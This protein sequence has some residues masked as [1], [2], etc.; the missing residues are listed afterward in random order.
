[1]EPT[2]ASATAAAA[3]RKEKD[4]RTD[5]A[6]VSAVNSG[7]ASSPE[8]EEPVPGASN[9]TPTRVLV[10]LVAYVLGAS[11]GGISVIMLLRRLGGGG[12]P[13]ETIELINQTLHTWSAQIAQGKPSHVLA[14]RLEIDETSQEVSLRSAPAARSS[15]DRS[16]NQ[17]SARNGNMKKNSADQPASSP[18]P[19]TVLLKESGAGPQANNAIAQCIIMENRQLRTDTDVATGAPIQWLFN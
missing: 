6:A 11:F 13:V 2:I 14:G 16:A 19:L 15:A 18:I 5:N 1:M 17:A 3:V 4:P 9:G 12:L 10:G 7:K 8:G